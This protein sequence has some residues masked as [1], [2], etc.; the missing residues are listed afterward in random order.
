MIQAQELGQVLME[1]H[2]K[3]H[4]GENQVMEQTQ[5]ETEETEQQKRQGISMKENQVS[6]DLLQK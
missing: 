2:S 1:Q 5:E 3:T 4:T 6:L